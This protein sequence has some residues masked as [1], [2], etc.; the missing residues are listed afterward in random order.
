MLELF[1]LFSFALESPVYVQNFNFWGVR[2]P[3]LRA[4]ETLYRQNLVQHR[5]VIQ[6]PTSSLYSPSYAQS[7]LWIL[8]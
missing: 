7:P 8:D 1:E 3:K 2:F 6:S 5:L 4:T